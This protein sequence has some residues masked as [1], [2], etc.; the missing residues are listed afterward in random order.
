MRISHYNNINFNIDTNGEITR[1]STWHIMPDENLD[2]ETGWIEIRELAAQ[3]S[4]NIGDP[5]RLPGADSQSYTEDPDYIISDISF[6]ALARYMYEVAYTGHKKPLTAVILGGVSETVNN[7]DERSKSATWLVHADSLSG[8]LPQIGD[9]LD[10]AGSSFLCENV[11]LQERG[12]KEWEVKLN[13][14]DMSVMMIG[15][16]SLSRDNNHDS[17]RQ[18]K[19][20]VGIDAYEDF[21]AAHDI[22]GDASSWAGDGYHISDIQ[23]SP[24]GKIAYY[25]TLEARHIEPRLLNVKHTE[26]FDG[27]DTNGNIRRIAVWNGCWRVHYNDLSTFENRVGEAAE[28]WAGAGTIITKMEPVRVTDLIYEV[29][30][31]AKA[32]ES[33]GSTAVEYNLDDRSNLG[34]RVDIICKEADYL[35]PAE[36]CGW[37]KNSQG[38]YEE[39]EAWDAA[40]LC[41]FV[42]ASAL[43]AEMIDAPLKCVF[44]SRISFL[45]G[46]SAAHVKMNLD[47]SRSSRV[48]SEVAGITG[49]WLKQSFNTEEV[50]DNEG[51]RW[52]K[53]IR[54]YIHSPA[55]QQWNTNYGGHK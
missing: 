41:P 49:S 19:W 38:Q 30:L 14:K 2:L 8:W 12:D 15:Q 21:L 34:N 28:D 6:N 1:R 11:Q 53:I 17:V 27:Y 52:T 32:P 37:Y 48:V 40:K 43:P 9:V 25:I 26:T 22:N 46:R 13:A 29:N 20:R 36:N 16:P 39:I 35:L 42:T 44:V 23:V 3:W 18:A 10:W 31:E 7:A 51:K 55:D 24:Y 54:S 5:W 47:W 4:G 50:F 33:S 45:R